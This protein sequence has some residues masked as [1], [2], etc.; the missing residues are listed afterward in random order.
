MELHCKLIT[1][2]EGPLPQQLVAE[3]APFIRNDGG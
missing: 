3:K 1:S 2:L